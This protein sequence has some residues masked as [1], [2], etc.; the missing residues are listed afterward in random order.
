MAAYATAERGAQPAAL[1]LVATDIAHAASA[2][3]AGTGFDALL[4]YLVE[5]VAGR[6]AARL[7]VPTPAGDEWLDTRGAADYLGVQR[8][9]MRPSRG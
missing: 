8:D 3:E 9:T 7:A 2:P 5:L 1:R 6:V 4:N